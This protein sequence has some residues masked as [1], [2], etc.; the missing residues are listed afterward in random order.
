MVGL[1]EVGILVPNITRQ[2]LNILPLILAPPLLIQRR[3]L[4]RGV[5]ERATV[6]TFT[7]VREGGLHFWVLRLL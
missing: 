2:P 1:D 3:H 5:G 7:Q 4:A 6:D